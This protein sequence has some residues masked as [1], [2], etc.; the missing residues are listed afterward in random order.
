MVV[1]R[2]PIVI[3]AVLG[4]ASAAGCDRDSS[5]KSSTSTSEQSSKEPVA[6][7]VTLSPSATELVLA[8]GG[9]DRLVGIDRY[10]AQLPTMVERDGHALP[11]VGDFLSPSFDAIA[12]LEPD[13]VLADA[14]QKKVTR[15]LAAAGIDTLALPMHRLSDVQR[16]LR[17]VGRALGLEKAATRA[18]GELEAGVA[19]ARQRSQSRGSR[20]VLVVIDRAPGALSGVVAAGPG[21]FAGELLDII[22]ADNML[23]DASVRYP[24]ISAEDIRRGEP[25]VIIDASPA[26]SVAAWRQLDVPATRARR[27]HKTSDRALTAP[28]PAVGRALEELERLVYG[29]ARE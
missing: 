29:S 1:A 21:S 27:V 14:L 17:K 18:A 7:V 10:S 13:L 15:G 28:S 24:R 20:R 25:E 9:G 26:D 11:S 19:G 5:K 23:D 4:L 8:V 16:G 22:G 6:R 2:T 3:A 12:R